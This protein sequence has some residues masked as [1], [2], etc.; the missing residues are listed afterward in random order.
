VMQ[1][2]LTNPLCTKGHLYHKVAEVPRKRTKGTTG[3]FG[4]KP[5][6]FS[7]SSIA[8]QTC[9]RKFSFGFGT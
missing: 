7:S 1:I 2:K 5:R 4:S 9:L 6:L 3:S 8:M